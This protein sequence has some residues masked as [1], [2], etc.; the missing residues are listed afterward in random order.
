[1]TPTSKGTLKRGGAQG[2]YIPKGFRKAQ[3]Q[4]FSPEQMGLFQQMFGNLGPESY[5]SKL[6]SGDQSFFEEQEAPAHREF[7]GYLGNLASRFSGMGTGGRH[8]SG[9]Q[10]AATAATSNFAQDLMSRRQDM[11]R[12]AINDLMG[13]SNQLLQQRPYDTELYQKPQKQ[14]VD[15]GGIGG[16]A[17]GGLGGFALGGPAG[18]MTGASLGYGIGSGKGANPKTDFS[19]F[20][21]PK[22]PQ[23][24]LSGNYDFG[25]QMQSGSAYFY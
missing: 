7:Q 17:L 9:F 5:L 14:G 11:Q 2:D 21:K 16:A 23:Q 22:S 10:N 19:V 1:M 8:S 3:L 15:W 13:F 18:A 24:S 12:Q 4:Q 25:S 20:N 6:A